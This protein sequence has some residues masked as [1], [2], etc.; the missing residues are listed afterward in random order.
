MAYRTALFLCNRTQKGRWGT[1]SAPR[2]AR[3][4]SKQHHISVTF[5]MTLRLQ[6]SEIVYFSGF[7]L[8][9]GMIS[10]NM[11]NVALSLLSVFRQESAHLGIYRPAEVT[12]KTTNG[13]ELTC[14]T[15]IHNQT[16]IALPSPYYKHVVVQG[17]IYSQLPP[18]YVKNIE[19]MPS[20]GYSGHCKLY[21]TVVK[22]CKDASVKL[23]PLSIEKK[24]K[25]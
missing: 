10:L 12:V 17:A 8:Y 3:A 11:R 5:L 25:S 16:D 24:R 23:A 18:E 4:D 21:D 1:A 7:G 20:N 22:Q 19:N 6:T 14:L 9:F 15:Y 2:R 13:D